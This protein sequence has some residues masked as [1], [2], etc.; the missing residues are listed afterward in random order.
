[1]RLDLVSASY[2]LDHTVCCDD[3]VAYLRDPHSYAGGVMQP[4]VVHETHMSWVFLV[5]DCAYKLKKTVQLPYLD[6]SSLE[7]REFACRQELRLNRRLAP[8]IYLDVIPLRSSSAGLTLGPA[9]AIV[10]WLVVMRRLDKTS[11]LEEMILQHRIRAD[12]LRRLSCTLSRFYK[13]ARKIHWPAERWIAHWR[14]MIFDNRP[15]LLDHRFNLPKVRTLRIDRSLCRFLTERKQLIISR[16]LANAIVEGHGDLR[17]EHIWMGTTPAVI[18]CLEF[19]AN[20]RVADPLDEIAYLSV[21]C[22]RL[23][24]R[25]VGRDIEAMLARELHTGPLTEL[26]A[27][28]RCYRATLKARLMLA[29]LL[30]P[31]PRNPVVWRPLAETY[32]EIA[33][34]EARNIERALRSSKDRPSNCRDE[35]G[36]RLPR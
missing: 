10:D 21:E 15:L 1:M 2:D 31:H 25:A 9:G 17:P 36:A 28:Y 23:G 30:E 22:Q 24:A 4:V 13:R 34:T 16:V 14:Q 20:L 26:L 6:F 18:D 33:D 5:G 35:D 12:Q 11:M 32:L 27:F 7:K 29:H 8:D 3:K 19:N